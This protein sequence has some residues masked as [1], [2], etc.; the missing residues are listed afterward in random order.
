MKEKQSFRKVVF[1]DTMTLHHM[2]LC[3]EYAKDNSLQFPT[4][5]PS[6]SNLKN[7]FCCGVQ[8]K[9]LRESLQTGLETIVKLSTDDVQIEY[10]PISE[11]EMLTGIA[12]GQARVSAAKEGIPH[13]MWSK[14]SQKQI[15]DRTTV[16]GLAAIKARI[17]G[18][19]SMLEESNV[20]VIR[21]DGKRTS[22]VI[23]LA[24]GMVGLVYIDEIDSI[25][26]ASAVVAGADFLVTADGYLRETVNR[27]RESNDQRYKE[28]RRQLN[29]LISEVLL[30]KSGQLELPQAF[31][32]TYRGQLKG[33]SSFP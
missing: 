30:A 4:D 6:I 31:T 11:I 27:V 17:D 5:E 25:V 3:L 8:E 15:R 22:D 16:E 33:V 19:P 18:L 23:E 26:Y 13:R 29:K 2:R 24:K 1:L 9:S 28:I 7:S 14:Y 20:R 10:A 21:S 12:E 32:I